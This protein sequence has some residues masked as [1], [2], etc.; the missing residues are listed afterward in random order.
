MASTSSNRLFDKGVSNHALTAKEIDVWK[1]LQSAYGNK[2]IPLSDLLA[3]ERGIV[4]GELYA[5]GFVKL[6]TS[7]GYAINKEIIGPAYVKPSRREKV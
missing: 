3:T 6:K 2:T 1:S 5:Q 7:S 4:T